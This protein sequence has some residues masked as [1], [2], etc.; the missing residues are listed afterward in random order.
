MGIVRAVAP[1]L[2]GSSGLTLRRFLPYDVIGAGLWVSTFILLGYIFW[3]SFDRVVHYAEQGALALGTV[4]VVVAGLTWFVRWIRDDPNRRQA[5]A[6][7]SRQA[8]RPVLRPVAAV[9]VP[10]A[11]L[12]RRPVMWVIN[13]LTPGELGLEVTTLLAVLGVSSFVF[14]ANASA[15]HQSGLGVFDADGLRMADRLYAPW[16]VDVAKV[17]TELGSF[18]VTSAVALLTAFFLLWRR[19]VARALLLVAGQVTLYVLVHVLKDAFD[20]P[21]PARP[22]VDADLSSFPSGHAAYAVT[23]WPPR[24]S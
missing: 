1:F 24:S 21:R 8:E 9:V 6:F 22:L 19:E 7:L 11:R 12:L 10:I 13:R 4:I 5:S 16:A 2:A 14:V 23:W 20:R 18:P 3:A 15:A 17:L